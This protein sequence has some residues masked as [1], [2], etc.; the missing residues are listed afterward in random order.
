MLFVIIYFHLNAHTRKIKLCRA[1]L[2]TKTTD[3]IRW[4]ENIF[5][6]ERW[7]WVSALTR[8]TATCPCTKGIKNAL[9]HIEEEPSST[10][11]QK[12]MGNGQFGAEWSFPGAGCAQPHSCSMRC[13]AVAVHLSCH[14]HIPALK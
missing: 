10:P 8:G 4:T 11:A 14:K 12:R 7:R 2:K 13:A 1:V 9:K 6:A 5:H 3:Q